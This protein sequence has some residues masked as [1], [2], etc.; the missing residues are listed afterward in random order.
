[1]IYTETIKQ[2]NT[3]K[4]LKSLVLNFLRPIYVF[5]PIPEDAVI[6]E[7]DEPN[8]PYHKKYVLTY[9]TPKGEAYINFTDYTFGKNLDK[10]WRLF[11]SK[12]LTG[13]LLELY[14]E[15]FNKYISDVVN[16]LNEELNLEAENLFKM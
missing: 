15:N 16:S 10:K 6:V 2:L 4:E 14:A 5:P 1:M 7:A 13:K 12:N 3:K 11:L 9:N 8:K